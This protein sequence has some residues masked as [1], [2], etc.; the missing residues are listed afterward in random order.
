MSNITNVTDLYPPYPAY[1]GDMSVG[2]VSPEDLF[3]FSPGLSSPVRRGPDDEVPILVERAS[4][5]TA[6]NPAVNDF[7]VGHKAGFLRLFNRQINLIRSRSQAFEDGHITVFDKTLLKL[8]QN[9]TD[10]ENPAAI[11]YY[12]EEF[13]GIHVGAS[14]AEASRVLSQAIQVPELLIFGS[15]LQMSSRVS[16]PDFDFT[17]T[18]ALI[19]SDVKT[20]ADDHQPVAEEMEPM[21]KRLWEVYENAKSD[22]FARSDSKSDD[23][24][25]AA[26]FLRDTAENTQ[27][28]LTDKPID[29]NMLAELQSTYDM[30]KATVVSLSGG[31]KRKFDDVDKELSKDAPRAPA[32]SNQSQRRRAQSGQY[33]S[34]S[35]DSGYGAGAP[36][37]RDN[38]ADIDRGHDRI[39]YRTLR[40]RSSS[41]REYPDRS[42]GSLRDRDRDREEPGHRGAYGS[43]RGSGH[44]ARPYGYRRDREVDS[45]RPR[46]YKDDMSDGG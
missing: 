33:P 46:E 6:L 25:G 31:K 19:N 16:L 7:V 38:N 32:N 40:R 44:R 24:I 15:C 2:E 4:Q 26:K 39:Q 17:E 34:R 27:Q 5:A 21:L 45:Y 42:P 11:Q 18:S 23:L 28:Y 36:S 41:P 13:L 22:Y 37:L 10:L 9:G 14:T 3:F 43:K 1:A 30:A 29:P 35:S 20:E 12:C 8:T